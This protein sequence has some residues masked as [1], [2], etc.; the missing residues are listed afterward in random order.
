MALTEL[1]KI[2]LFE[3]EEATG[4]NIDKTR[5]KVGDFGCQIGSSRSHEGQEPGALGSKL[6]IEINVRR[7][8]APDGLVHSPTKYQ[9]LWRGRY[10]RVASVIEDDHFNLRLLVEDIE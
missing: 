5:T 9:V 7:P 2:T 1:G 8:S 6:Y 3:E 4:E 10:Y